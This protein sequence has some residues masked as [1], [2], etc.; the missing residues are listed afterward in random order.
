MHAGALWAT[1]HYYRMDATMSAK[2]LRILKDLCDE[3]R[4]KSRL[5]AQLVG[6][7][8]RWKMA[9]EERRVRSGWVYDPPTYC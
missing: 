7:Y 3:F 6:R 5:F 4:L 2:I 9:H 8:V 1:R